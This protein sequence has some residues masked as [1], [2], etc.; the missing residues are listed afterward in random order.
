M[1]IIKREQ[2]TEVPFVN[3]FNATYEHNGIERKWAYASRTSSEPGQCDAVMII[4]IIKHE[5]E[6]LKIVLIKQYR[7]PVGKYIIEFPAGLVDK[8]ETPIETAKRE[9]KEETGME[10]TKIL[11][12]SP[13]TYN[14]AGMSDETITIVFALVDGK[15]STKLNESTEDIEV[16]VLNKEQLSELMQNKQV[17][18]AAKTWLFIKMFLTTLFSEE[19]ITD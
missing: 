7:V 16:T 4:G 12:V 5:N 10:I 9:F 2:V 19:N 1:K 6:P 14:S 13:S 17:C 15:P 18:F 8:G 11:N 3:L